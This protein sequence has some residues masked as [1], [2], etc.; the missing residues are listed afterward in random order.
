MKQKNTL[1]MAILL[2]VFVLIWIGEGIYTSANSSTISEKVNQEISPIDPTFDAN[3]I[4][5]LKS[6][7]KISPSL[8]LQEAPP[9]PIALP[10][11]KSTAE[12]STEGKLSSQ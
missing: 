5:N 9:A 1:V 2:F 8:N 6:R 4:N 3:T 7:E 11:L 10:T 12:A